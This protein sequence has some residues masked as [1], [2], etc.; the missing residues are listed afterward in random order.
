MLWKKMIR[1]LKENKGAYLA[2]III[3]VIGLMVFTSFSMVMDNLRLSQQSFYKNQNFADGFI[4]VQAMPPSEIEKLQDIQG[5]ND[6]QGRLVKDVKVLFPNR[7]ENVYL[8]L[9]SVDPAK[10]NPINGVQLKQG[11]PL[12]NKEMNILIDNK[13][14]EAN[15]LKLNEEIEII[16]D[17]KKR[18]LR[19]IGV[20]RSPEF[21][22]AL[23]TSSDL[24][25]SPESFGIAYIPFEVMKTLFPERETMNNIVFTLRPG[26]DYDNVKE[27]LK[28]ELKPYGLKSI[29]PRKD[30]TSHLLLTQEL[31][32][33]EAT[34]RVL[35]LL[36]LSIAGMILYIML[37]RMVE[38]Q[39]GQ[40]GIL[41]AFGYTHKEI[42][43]HYMSYALTIGILGGII[44]GILGIA[45]SFPFTTLY[46]TYFN[47]PGLTSKFSPLYLVLS[48][49][50]SLG[51][52]L[53]AGYQGCKGILILQPAEAMRPPAPPIGKKTWLEKITIFWNMLT[54]QGKM[55]VRNMSRNKSRSIFIFLGIMFTFSLLGLTW[56]MNDLSQRMLF[57]QYEKVETYDV[58]VSLSNPLNQKKV[59]RELNHFPGVTRVEAMAEIPVTLKNKWYKKDVVLLGIPEDSTLYNILDKNYN[60]VDP[61]K[62]GLL[63]SERLAK[64]LGAEVGTKLNVESLMIKD[65][66]KA[67]QL[68]V[69]GV[70]PQYLGLNAYMDINSLQEF[71]GQ[72]ELATSF[73]LR[74]DE[75][76][77]A[78]LQNEFRKSAA[79]SGIDDQTERLAQTKELM[80][81]FYGM[82]F[83]LALIGIITGFAI[84]YNSS[85]ITL[86]ERSHELASMM[87]LGMTPAEVLSVITFEQWFIGIFAMLAG[88]PMSQI[89]LIG[90]S[91][92]I[93]N[94]V[95]TMPTN[96]T[97][98]SFL[99]AFFVTAA[100]IWIAQRFAGK[101]I[102]KLS[103]VDV[104]KSR[105]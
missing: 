93:S 43:S 70:I 60:K 51:F 77:I 3:I 33:L 41:K 103:L 19:I 65:P 66:D 71:L 57:D 99:I 6:V 25:P 56:S 61:P 89:L 9:V 44:G 48:I 62:N 12:S 100:S 8:R 52:S 14:F 21:I 102:Q 18:A 82:I 75:E 46:Q 7:D 49:L 67:K 105:E 31:K 63:I 94:D 15:N 26:A 68:E 30:Q 96:I 47:M 54:V 55:A 78:L 86:S 98:S 10:K 97:A 90:M 22:Y 20:G 79:V 16:A 13:F 32:G 35:P 104:L 84:I 88:I 2:T 72:G 59:S 53:F 74:M 91:Q 69:V 23:R 1:D 76:S 42:L 40:I 37:K 73:M 17:G 80:A 11:I 92:S 34:A 64:L 45:L 101:K 24:Y 4:E 83:I 38:Q 95:Y 50:L 81:S 85:V 39:R 58:K 36:F 27:R 87:V 5:I 29:Y 28:P